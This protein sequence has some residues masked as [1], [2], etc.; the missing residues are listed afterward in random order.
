MKNCKKKKIKSTVGLSVPGLP[1]IQIFNYD[2]FLYKI[3]LPEGRRLKFLISCR[4][5]V[6]TTIILSFS[7]YRKHVVNYL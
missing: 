2:H 3:Y 7:L 1:N 6:F 4:K 5:V